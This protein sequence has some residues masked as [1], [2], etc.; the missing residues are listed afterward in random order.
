MMDFLQWMGFVC[1]VFGTLVLP[2]RRYHAA[3][4]MIVGCTALGMW[5]SM[6][7]PIAWGT[8]AVQAFVAIA[9]M[10]NIVVWRRDE[11]K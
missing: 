3:L 6:L 10:R 1:L 11:I 5:A 8:F 4:W 7:E 2:T 9:W